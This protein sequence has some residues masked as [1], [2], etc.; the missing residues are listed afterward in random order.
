MECY[1]KHQA[2]C[3]CQSVIVPT[4][5]VRP[6]RYRSAL[7][8]GLLGSGVDV[9]GASGPVEARVRVWLDVGAGLTPNNYRVQFGGRLCPKRS[10]KLGKTQAAMRLACQG[11]RDLEDALNGNG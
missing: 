9:G 1:L 2:G 8:G 10:G 4:A 5:E 3:I 11:L 7:L 6:G